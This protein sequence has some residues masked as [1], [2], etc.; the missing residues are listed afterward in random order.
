MRLFW[1]KKRIMLALLGLALLMFVH[2]YV[3]FSMVR[4]SSANM[5]VLEK[6]LQTEQEVLQLLQEKQDVSVEH[7]SSE[8]FAGLAEKIPTSAW[9]DYL[10][11]ELETIL[12]GNEAIIHS[13]SA[14]DDTS[15][16][17]SEQVT[18]DLIVDENEGEVQG[19]DSEMGQSMDVEGLKTFRLFFHFTVSSYEDFIESVR[20]IQEMNRII[21]IEQVQVQELVEGGLQINLGLNAFYLPELFEEF[22][23]FVQSDYPFL[24]AAE[25][26]NPFQ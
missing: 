10:F 18:E 13:V 2:L 9:Q 19:T 14:E 15:F 25:K 21:Q 20:Q 3:Y 4:P 12:L 16:V 26:S 8:Q 1:S 17:F 23:E 6:Q 24:P 11:A 22:P 7:S 5:N